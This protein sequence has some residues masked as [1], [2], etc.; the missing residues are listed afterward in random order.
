V[1]RRGAPTVGPTPL[2]SSFRHHFHRLK[3]FSP[4]EGSGFIIPA[5]S[6][7]LYRHPI[8]RK[9]LALL[10][11]AVVPGTKTPVPFS[12][13]WRTI[14]LDRIADVISQVTLETIITKNAKGK[15][16]TA[17]Y[18]FSIPLITLNLKPKTDQPLRAELG[19]LRGGGIRTMQRV[20][21]SNKATAITEDVPSEAELTPSLWGSL[22]FKLQ[23]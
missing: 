23:P 21:W 11:R 5:N 12:S 20:Y 16:D 8:Q 19:I 6:I 9:T 18:E 3:A 14:T 1:N 10:Y 17:L 2:R 4:P 15:A 7:S 13:P 22:R